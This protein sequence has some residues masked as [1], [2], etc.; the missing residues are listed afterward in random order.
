MNIYVANLAPEVNEEMLQVLFEPYGEIEKVR[1]MIDFQCNMSKGYAFVTMPDDESAK[2]AIKEKHG[3]LFKNKKIAV[4][5]AGKTSEKE[6]ITL[7]ESKKQDKNSEFD[8][9]TNLPFK[10]VVKF[11]E[12]SK[13]YGFIL[14]K[15][16]RELFF[17]QSGLAENTEK[18]QSGQNV[19]FNIQYGK[20]GFT[21]I[22]II[23]DN[24]SL[25]L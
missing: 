3:S 17:H 24:S 10:G 8:L 23:S 11:F 1:L 22:N 6:I 21:A 4:R 9:F 12:E 25:N 5:E 20:K 7:K 15:N 2:V 19:E 13:G 18:L 16:Q 14:L